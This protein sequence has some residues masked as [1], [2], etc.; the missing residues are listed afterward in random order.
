MLC[1]RPSLFLSWND[2]KTKV[3][4]QSLC[5]FNGTLQG[6]N[7]LSNALCLRCFH[8]MCSLKHVHKFRRHRLLKEINCIAIVLSREQE[9]IREDANG[10]IHSKK[11]ELLFIG[12]NRLFFFSHSV[13]QRNGL[14]R[15]LY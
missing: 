13:L 4:C 10:L 9:G 15:L 1:L 8:R 2:L 7:D 5:Q 12:S 14:G 3:I 11:G 6:K